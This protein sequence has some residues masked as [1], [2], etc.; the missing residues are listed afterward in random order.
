MLLISMHNKDSYLDKV[1]TILKENGIQKLRRV[2]KSSLNLPVEDETDSSPPDSS[3]VKNFDKAVVAEIDKQKLPI[4]PKLMKTIEYV[5]ENGEGGSIYTLPYEEILEIVTRKRE[6]HMKITDYLQPKL[7]C[8]HINSAARDEVIKELAVHAN[9]PSLVENYDRFLDDVFQREKLKSTGIG[10]EIAIP[11]AR[12]DS[13]KRY[14]IVFG[15]SEQGIDFN[16]IDGKPVNLIFLM[17]IPKEDV[18]G[19]LKLLA[20]LTRLLKKKEF[21]SQLMEAKNPAEVIEI[22]KKAEK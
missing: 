2:K 19:Y 12:T 13:V 20:F 4:L 22:F 16:A 3:P 5:K 1:E 11:H 9:D 7:I 18:Q 15:K 8:T 10:Y 17:G 14:F 6:A 21:R